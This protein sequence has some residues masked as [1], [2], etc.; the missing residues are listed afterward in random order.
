MSEPLIHIFTATIK[1]GQ[2]EGFKKYAQENA[3]FTK[4]K[5]PRLLAFHQYVNEDGNKVSV[6]QVHP[7]ADSMEFFMQEVVAQH[8][9]QAYQYLEEGSE[10][11][12][13]YGTPSD[14]ILDGLRQYGVSF[15]VKPYHVGGFTRLQAGI[16]TGA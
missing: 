4:A 11:S 12:E 6:V 8:G 3:E 2:L 16:S 7:D 5:H 10:S 15:S 13:I 9:V 1:E 14:A